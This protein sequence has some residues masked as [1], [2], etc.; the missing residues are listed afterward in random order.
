M[1]HDLALLNYEH[2]KQLV[3][4]V[5]I[6]HKYKDPIGRKQSLRLLAESFLHKKIQ[7]GEHSSI[8]D[9]Q[10]A[11]NLYKEV[12]SNWERELSKKKAKQKRTNHRKTIGDLFSSFKSDENKKFIS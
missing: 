1:N 6:Y 2:P 9:A 11:M 12:E 7:E 10:I 3:R 8:E 5:N 4:D